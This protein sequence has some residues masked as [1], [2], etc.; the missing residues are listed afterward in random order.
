L[1]V[2]FVLVRAIS[3]GIIPFRSG[4]ILHECTGPRHSVRAAK[5]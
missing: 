3:G 4:E 1:K 2:R 5:A